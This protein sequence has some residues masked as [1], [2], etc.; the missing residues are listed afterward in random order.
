MTVVLLMLCNNVVTK[1]FYIFTPTHNG[2]TLLV[3]KTVCSTLYI[4]GLRENQRVLALC[5]MENGALFNILNLAANFSP[6]HFLCVT[7]LT[8]LYR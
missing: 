8:V 2:S 5:A 1:S 3:I 4:M 7:I 6:S